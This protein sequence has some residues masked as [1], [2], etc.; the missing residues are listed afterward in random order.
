MKESIEYR[1][2][3]ATK[4]NL[5]FD[6]FICLLLGDEKIYRTN[7]RSELLR[8]K[9]KFNDSI[10]LEDFEVQ[11]HRGVNKTMIKKLG[12]LGF[13]DQGENII[14]IGGTGAGKS[15]LAQALGQRSCLN[16]FES[17]YFPVNKLFKQ[18]QEAEAAGTYLKLLERIKKAK[19]VILDDFGL[20]NYSHAE[21][22]TLYD[23]LE[24]PAGW[25]H[26]F[27]DEVIAEAIIDR[28]TSSSHIIEIKGPSYRKNH[29]PKEKI[30][31]KE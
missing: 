3:E 5:D 17:L 26:L 11:P 29:L 20:R 16:G 6:E 18:V 27:E 12:T 9:A 31:C 28:L 30:E 21:A 25:R 7:R 4:G 22:T 1:M 2:S 15:Y 19:L 10:S 24:E 14:F 8:R 13:I 23:L